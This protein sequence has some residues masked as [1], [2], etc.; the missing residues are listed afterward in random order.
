[1]NAGCAIYAAD[2]A[3]SIKEG[4]E[5]AGE[6]IESGEGLKKLEQLKEATNR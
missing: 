2:G 6:S 5:I 4:I 1:M 3:K